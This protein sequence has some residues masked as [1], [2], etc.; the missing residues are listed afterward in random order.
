M[1]YSSAR[2]YHNLNKLNINRTEH[3]LRAAKSLTQLLHNN[4]YINQLLFEGIY[5]Q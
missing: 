4:L 1:F 3:T 5:L 2:L